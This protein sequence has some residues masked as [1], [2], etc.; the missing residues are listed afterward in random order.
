MTGVEE[1]WLSATLFTEERG[2]DPALGLA[3]LKA[4]AKALGLNSWLFGFSFA[5][6]WAG[7][8]LLMRRP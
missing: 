4:G 7:P 2:L 6:M 8:M 5:A 1:G 3:G